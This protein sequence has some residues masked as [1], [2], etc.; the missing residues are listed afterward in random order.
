M[1]LIY[2]ILQFRVKFTFDQIEVRPPCWIH[3]N[4]FNYPTERFVE[5]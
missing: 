4:I 2:E 5:I 1:A 3:N